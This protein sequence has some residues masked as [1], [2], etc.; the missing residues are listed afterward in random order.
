MEDKGK[1]YLKIDLQ[2]NEVFV[3]SLQSLAQLYLFTDEQFEQI[4]KLSLGER[5]E[6]QSWM[7]ETRI[8]TIQREQ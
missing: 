6:F 7:D 3:Y 4:S 5:I 2:R 1:K 8:I